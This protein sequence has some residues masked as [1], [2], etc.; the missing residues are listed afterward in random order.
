MDI[1]DLRE[2]CNKNPAVTEDIKWGN[3]LCFLIAGKMFCVSGLEL[4]LTVSFKVTPEEFDE[5]T[6]RPGIIPAPYL[7]RYHWILVSKMDAFSKKEWEYFT[8][9]SYALVRN[10]LSK[11]LKTQYGLL[12]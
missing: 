10:K 12:H 7:S 11:K 1:E 3:D 2:I 4:P 5:L 8:K 9:Q 6:N